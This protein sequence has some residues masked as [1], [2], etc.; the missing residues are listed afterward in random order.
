[1][2]RNANGKVKH[3]NIQSTSIKSAGYDAEKQ[4]LH[5]NFHNTGHYVY[6]DVTPE[7]YEAFQMSSSKGSFLHNNIKNQH[8]FSKL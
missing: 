2:N 3:S 1:M 7:K 4:E 6:H 8:E 5:V